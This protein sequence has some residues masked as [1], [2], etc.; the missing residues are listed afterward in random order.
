MSTWVFITSTGVGLTKVLSEMGC[1]ITGAWTGCTTS[2]VGIT[3]WFI[4]FCG[5][6]GVGFGVGTN[7]SLIFISLITVV[8]GAKV[9]TGSTFWACS[10]LSVTWVGMTPSCTGGLTLSTFCTGA[11][12]SSTSSTFSRFLLTLVAINIIIAINNSTTPKL[13]NIPGT[14]VTHFK[15]T[16]ISIYIPLFYNL[17]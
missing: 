6:T 11:E 1:G 5:I 3:I 14:V 13:I 2:L 16:F 15:I 12:L 8:L 4:S 10:K 17:Y 9:L 7:W